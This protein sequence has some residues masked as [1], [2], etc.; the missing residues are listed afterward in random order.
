MDDHTARRGRF[1]ARC[2]QPLLPSQ[3][4]T[5]LYHG[6]LARNS[7]HAH[8]TSIL[9]RSPIEFLVRFCSIVTD[10]EAIR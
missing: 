5:A 3:R 6:R 4:A 1:D 8:D 10:A 7:A 9:Q 2:M